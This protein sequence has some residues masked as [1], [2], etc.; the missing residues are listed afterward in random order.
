MK[1]TPATGINENE[2]LSWLMDYRY[3]YLKKDDPDGAKRVKA[4]EKLLNGGNVDL[5]LPFEFTV[6][7]DT[8]KIDG[9][10]Y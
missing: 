6:Y 10:V 4:Y 2:F 5:I 9:N 3:D 7:G 8:F 1:G